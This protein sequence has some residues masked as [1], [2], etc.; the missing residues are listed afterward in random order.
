MCLRVLVAVHNL[1]P[2]HVEAH[3]IAAVVVM[4]V[5]APSEAATREANCVKVTSMALEKV[6]KL[7]AG[8][9]C[10]E[11]PVQSDSNPKHALIARH[12]VTR[13]ASPVLLHVPGNL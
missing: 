13:C 10:M 11:V 1:H 2:V 4:I 7:T 12:F 8:K 5:A 9:S 3:A 6:P